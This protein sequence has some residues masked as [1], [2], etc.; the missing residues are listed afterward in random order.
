MRTFLNKELFHTLAVA[1]VAVACAAAATVCQ[2]TPAQP[3]RWGLVTADAAPLRNAPT[4]AAAV[5]AQLWRGE[6]VELRAQ[7]KGH[8]QVWEHGRER[9]G[10]LPEEQVWPLPTDDAAPAQL[11]AQVRLAA[12]QAGAESLLMGLAAAYVQAAPPARMASAEGAEVLALWGQA[13]ER[14]AERANRPG[15]ARTAQAAA[16]GHLEVASRFG[17]KFKTL[18]QEGRSWL[19]YD[20]ALHQRVLA[21]PATSAHKAQAALALTRGEC[22]EPG[23]HPQAREQAERWREQV[24]AQVPQDALPPGLQ[25]QMR[26]RRAT[27]RAGLAWAALRRAQPSSEAAAE[28]L[29]AALD[30]FARLP[31]AAL[32]DAEL[33]LWDE[34]ALRLNALRWAALPQPRE[35]SLSPA[36]HLA[37][38]EGGPGEQGESCVEL[39]AAAQGQPLQRRCTFGLP[40]LASASANREGTAVAMSVQTLE[41]WAELWV[42][43]KAGAQWLLQVLPPAPSEPELGYAELAGW[44]PGGQEMLVVR[45]ARTLPAGHGAGGTARFSRRFEVLRIDTLTAQR[46][47]A[48]PGL[49]GAFSRWESPTWRGAS[50]SLR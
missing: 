20:G 12:T 48:E 23:A 40:W 41:G 38:V 30:D 37:R 31:R 6:W 43:R 50:L 33:P 28:N 21:L 44:V 35:R 42:W 10:H 1:A 32:A 22:M 49:L 39:R 25:Q 5:H 16:A 14:L 36:L 3:L 45:E 26:L 27:V 7:G 46:W 17:L 9:G 29:H 11:W 19:C 2:A 47:A 8:V 15:A 18:Q 34:A 24:L 4:E 13:A